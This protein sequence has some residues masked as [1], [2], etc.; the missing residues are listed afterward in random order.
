MNNKTEE[1]EAPFRGLEK[2]KKTNVPADVLNEPHLM[3]YMKKRKT[4]DDI[5]LVLA[6]ITSVV[7]GMVLEIFLLTGRMI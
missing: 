2:W 1:I 4:I 6:I 3:A 5:T 7:W